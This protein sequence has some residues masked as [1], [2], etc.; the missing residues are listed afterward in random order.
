MQS[1]SC[2]VAFDLSARRCVSGGG[3]VSARH[4]SFYFWCVQMESKVKFIEVTSQY[5]VTVLSPAVSIHLFITYQ[6]STY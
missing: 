6:T 3:I 5:F 2:R 1:A 4:S